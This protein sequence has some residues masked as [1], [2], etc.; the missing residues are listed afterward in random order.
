MLPLSPAAVYLSRWYVLDN[1]SSRLAFI[2]IRRIDIDNE[3][4]RNLHR[5][6]LDLAWEHT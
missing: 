2:L 6:L 5:G 4:H 3:L 1:S